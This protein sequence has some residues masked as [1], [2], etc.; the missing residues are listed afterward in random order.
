MKNKVIPIK[1]EEKA[2]L[3]PFKA[4]FTI[5]QYELL[6]QCLNSLV[7]TYGLQA[8]RVPKIMKRYQA[9]FSTQKT[10]KKVI[11]NIM[12]DE[13]LIIET[14]VNGVLK[15][16]AQQKVDIDICDNLTEIHF[17]VINEGYLKNGG[18]ILEK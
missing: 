1:T 17:I 13:A 16:V 9:E 14:A 15:S 6:L 8:G 3:K 5:K 4:E 18:K 2:I 7:A 11:I 10:L 12:N